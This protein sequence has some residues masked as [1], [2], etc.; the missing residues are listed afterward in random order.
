MVFSNLISS[1]MSM[2]D[3]RTDIYGKT[4]DTLIQVGLGVFEGETFGLHLVWNHPPHDGRY[5]INSVGL[6]FN[7]CYLSGGSGKKVTT[8]DS[9]NVTH[10][11]F[12]FKVW[13]PRVSTRGVN[14]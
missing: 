1:W 6:E 3:L 8:P 12:R 5:Y 13:V 14:V 4:Q 9:D 11:A 7:I 2:S 10:A